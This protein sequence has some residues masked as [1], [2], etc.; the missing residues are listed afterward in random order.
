M[1]D[2]KTSDVIDRAAEGLKKL[3]EVKAPE[4]AK[5]VKTGAGKERPPMNKDWWQKRAAAVLRRVAV[6]GPVG[7][8]KLR[9]KYRN[10]AKNK[11][12]R[13]NLKQKTFG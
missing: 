8:S 1:L 5:F 11:I 10:K 7:V 4:W 3:D 2:T 12:C 13:N 6:T 9:S